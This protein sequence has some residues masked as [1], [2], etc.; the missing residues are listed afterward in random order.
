MVY[1][2]TVVDSLARMYRVLRLAA[3]NVTDANNKYQKNP[4]TYTLKALNDASQ[5]LR[6]QTTIV[7]T[8]ELEATSEERI[9]A[10]G[11][12]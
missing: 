4:N 10:K 7:D 8:Y 12:V 11:R 9:I 5:I 2:E 6:N 3:E 1:R